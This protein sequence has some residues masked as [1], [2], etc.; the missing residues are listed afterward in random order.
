MIFSQT[1][2]A[3]LIRWSF[4]FF[5]SN[6]LLFWMIGLKYLPSVASMPLE[7]FRIKGKVVLFSFLMFSYFGQLAL[8]AFIPCIAIG[9]L[10]FI[11]P[12]RQIIFVI[13]VLV[14]AVIAMLLVV[15][16][17]AYGLYRFHLNGVALELIIK[18]LHEE[19]F[20]LS[21]AE[22]LSGF[23]IAF[24]I[25]IIESFLA[26]GLW[27]YIVKKN[28]LLGCGKWIVIF[29]SCCIY[30]S[31]SM[32]FFS[33]NYEIMNRQLLDVARILPLYQNFI[34]ALLPAKHSLIGIERIG[35]S[36]F[37]QPKQEYV[38]LN[39]PKKILQFD[40]ESP[41]P[42][43]V[44]IIA[45]D[46]WRFD[47]LNA[48][49]TPNLFQFAK[50]SW[51]FS[52]H[53]SGGNATGPGIF[54]LFYGIPAAYWTAMETERRRPVLLEEFQKRNFAMGIFSSASLR[55]PAFQHTVFHGINN[56]QLETPG[57]TPYAKDLAITQQFEKFIEIVTQ[58]KK[59]FFSFLFYDAAHSYCSSDEDLKPFQPTVK[60]CARFALT[61]GEDPE[62]YLNRYKNALLLVDQQIKRVLTILESRHLLDKTLVIITGDHGEEFDDNH[63]NYWGHAGNFTHY[64][65]QTPLIIHWPGKSPEVF[66]HQTS[67]FDLA[68]T[69]MKELLGCSSSPEEYS[70]GTYLLDKRPRPYLIVGSYIDFGVI[71]QDRITTVFPMGNFS[72]DQLNGRPMPQAKLD[73]A[74]MQKVFRDLRRFYRN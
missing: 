43:N 6:A 74:V 19:M 56:L 11:F 46:T 7:F 10:I 22:E 28:I 34:A 72:I 48:N 69:L 45:I 66:A 57:K 67:H 35:E 68:P 36:Y 12:K 50:E 52:Q 25:L 37:V 8:L 42:L 4:W 55:M 40:S 20:S 2:R 9:C 47:M 38:P 70:I 32:I 49:V 58:Q 13:S 15:D 39:Y 1:T 21:W 62:P 14:A 71:Q 33:A 30:I 16:V 59:P 17:V 44:V 31:Y 29:L 53:F 18:G 24:G 65:V 23:I 54:T 51:F 64:Q 63:L 41:Q 27:C 3:Q 26:F 73:V 5:L 60:F 61:S